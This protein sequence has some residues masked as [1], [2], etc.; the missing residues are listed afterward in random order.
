[1]RTVGRG[2]MDGW[3]TNPYSH[4]HMVYSNSP[5]RPKSHQEIRKYIFPQGFY[6][7]DKIFEF[8]MHVLQTWHLKNI[9]QVVL[10][11]TWRVINYNF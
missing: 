5:I 4:C 10:N 2:L 6:V 11:L 1:M 8:W 7:K 3:E 9:K